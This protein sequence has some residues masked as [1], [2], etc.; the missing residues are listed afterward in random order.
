MITTKV[1][2]INGNFHIRLLKG[3]TVISEI[4]CKEK[5]DIG[6]CCSYLLR[7]FDKLGGNNR[8]SKK[9]RSRQKNIAPIGKIWYETQMYKLRKGK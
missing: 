6:Y 7:W 3:E 2:Y 5:Q 8:M 4:A 1:T 9:S